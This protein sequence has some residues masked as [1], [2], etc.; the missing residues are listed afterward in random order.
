SELAHEELI[1]E[2]S[3]VAGAARSVKDCLIGV[4][5]RVQFGGDQLERIIPTDRFVVSGIAMQQHWMCEP[6]LRSEP[7]IGLLREFGNAPLLKELRRDAFSCRFFGNML[8]AVFA[9]LEMR[10]LLIGFGPRTARTVNATCL[11]DF[12]HRAHA[13]NE[14]HL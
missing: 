3:F 9:K 14:S 10:A 7:L 4:V 6:S 1:K 8:G 11:I 12:Q 13:A 5:K 2:R